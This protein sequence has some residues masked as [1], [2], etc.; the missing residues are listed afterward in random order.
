MSPIPASTKAA[1]NKPVGS[2]SGQH[3]Q[4]LASL[5]SCFA[6]D[7]P[8]QRVPTPCTAVIG[9]YRETRQLGRIII[10]KGYSAA[11]PIIILSC[12]ITTKRS[13]S[14]SSNSRLRRTKR[15]VSFEGFYQ[16]QNRADILYF[17][18]S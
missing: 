1:L 12:S 9:M 10:R 3:K 7:V 8:E 4:F 18:I 13:I 14:I 15:A 6:L 11:Q 17:C 16:L 2:S 5:G